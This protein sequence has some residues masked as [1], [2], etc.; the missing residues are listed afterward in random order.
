M[1]ASADLREVRRLVLG[2][3]ST[4]HHIVVDD[5][6]N[7]VQAIH[8]GVVIHRAF[9]T[10]K[11][12]SA[13]DELAGFGVE[14]TVLPQGEL[15]GAFPV[16]KASRVF[17]LADRPRARTLSSLAEDCRDLVVLDG[18]RLAGNIG[19]VTRTAYALGSSGLALL[20]SDLR[21]VYD[22]RLVRASRGLIFHLPAVLAR[23]GQ[24]TTFCHQ[25]DIP[26]VTTDTNSD[27]DVTRLCALRERI[28]LVLGGERAGCSTEVRAKGQIQVA[29]TM[30]SGV[31]SLNVSVAAGIVLHARSPYN[32]GH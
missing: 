32:L 22:R 2:R 6:E 9:C 26:I 4:P 7:I 30:R 19:A 5:L 14:T 31:D 24:L 23:P 18:V 3:Q 20:N 25:H 17:A 12:E 11:D 1:S 8:A 15:R 29:I 10:A 28:A 27:C 13:A 21:S 16:E